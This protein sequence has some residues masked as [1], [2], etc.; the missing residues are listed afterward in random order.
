V[1]LGTLTIRSHPFKPDELGIL[2]IN[3]GIDA[4]NFDDPHDASAS[5]RG[6]AALTRP[7]LA[8]M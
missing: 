8:G 1:D 6:G 7:A 5:L 4:I 2:D 3:V